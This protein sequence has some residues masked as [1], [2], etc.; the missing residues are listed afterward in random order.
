[1]KAIWMLAGIGLCALFGAVLWFAPKLESKAEFH[2]FENNVREFGQ[3]YFK[4]QKE[5]GRPPKS[6]EE[7]QPLVD[8]ASPGLRERVKKDEF[9]V[10]WGARIGP[11]LPEA[12]VR[13]VIVGKPVVNGKQV[14]IHQDGSVRHYT[15]DETLKLVMATA[16]ESSTTGK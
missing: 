8:R 2:K 5:N 1:M 10:I 6:L 9:T 14:V 11:E 4:Y 15:P 3:V 7:L 12:R 13:T 16:E